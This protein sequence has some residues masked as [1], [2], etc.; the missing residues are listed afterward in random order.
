MYT[1]QGII[2]DY[3]T[4]KPLYG[5]VLQEVNNPSNSFT[6]TLQGQYKIDL[7][8]VT[9]IM[10]TANGYEVGIVQVTEKDSV[11]NIGLHSNKTQVTEVLDEQTISDELIQEE[12][13]IQQTCSKKRG[14]LGFLS[15]VALGIL[16]TSSKSKK[17]SS[18]NG[19]VKAKI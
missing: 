14:W 12:E 7:S 10:A 17:T 13:P 6:T 18:L 11:V 19:V 15:G 1:I 3:E 8:G 5:A 4:G 9:H 16:I 2:T